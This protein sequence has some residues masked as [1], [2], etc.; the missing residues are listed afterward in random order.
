MNK[1][2]AY[3]LLM[4]L[5]ASLATVAGYFASALDVVANDLWQRAEPYYKSIGREPGVGEGVLGLCI[6]LLFGFLT[7]L[8]VAVVFL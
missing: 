3:K 7:A 4:V 6:V 5:V 1:S 8:G 2:Y